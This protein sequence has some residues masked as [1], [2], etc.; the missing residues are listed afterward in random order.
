MV[1]H[2]CYSGVKSAKTIPKILM[3]MEKITNFMESTA[4][5]PK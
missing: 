2:Q 3:K 5:P 1:G 4:H